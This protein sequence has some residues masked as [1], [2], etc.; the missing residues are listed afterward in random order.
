[1]SVIFSYLPEVQSLRLQHLC[2]KFY[3]LVLPRLFYTCPIEWENGRAVRVVANTIR[4]EAHL[5]TVELAS[6]FKLKSVALLNHKQAFF[7]Y[8]DSKQNVKI[9]RYDL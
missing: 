9:G 1:M 8:K 3:L 7:S 2:R 4:I 6:E 5:E